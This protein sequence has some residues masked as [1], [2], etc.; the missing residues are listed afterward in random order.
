MALQP[1]HLG[2]GSFWEPRNLFH[3]GWQGSLSQ[4]SL[5]FPSAGSHHVYPVL[6]PKKGRVAASFLVGTESV[7]AVVLRW[8]F[9]QRNHFWNIFLLLWGQESG[10]LDRFFVMFCFVLFW[11]FFGGEGLKRI[12]KH[13]TRAGFSS[14]VEQQAKR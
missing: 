12:S 5:F 7:N 9:T 6:A 14:A 10:F 1:Q 8:P 3:T 13:G 2:A 11:V 4:G